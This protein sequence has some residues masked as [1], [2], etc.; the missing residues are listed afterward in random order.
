MPHFSLFQSIILA[1]L[2]GV[3]ELFPVSSLG[4]SIVLPHIL[5]LSVNIKSAAFLPLLTT[6][7]IGTATAL[8]IYFR[9]DWIR[10]IRGYFTGD[11]NRRLLLLL[12]VGTIPTGLIGVIF[13]KKLE[14]LFGSYQVAAF[15][16]IL[17]A[18]LLVGGEWLRKK[19]QQSKSLEHLSYPQ[20][21]WIGVSQS[22]ALLPGF[23]RSGASLVGGLIVGLTHE[24]AARFS[25]LL[26]TPIIFAAGVLEVPKLFKASE[27]PD[28][29]PAVIGGIVAGISAYAATAF[30]MKY[31]KKNEV[32]AL[33]PFALYCLLLG[34]LTFII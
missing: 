32:N 9:D 25:F 4:N 16:L 17:N 1:I 14:A 5:H 19:K 20:A 2:Q 13:E 15:F 3:T 26:A 27:R 6:F 31:F 7:H 18:G 30:L 8:L 12:I 23:S 24:A 21:F 33:Y 10:L 28:L 22:L 34:L 11:K 29:L